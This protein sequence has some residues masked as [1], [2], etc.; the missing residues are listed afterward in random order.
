KNTDETPNNG[1]DDD[2]NGYVDDYDGWNAYNSTGNIPSANHGTHVAGIAGAIGNNEIGISGVNWN[3]KTMPIAGSSGNEATVV[4]AYAYA[5][6]MRARY[7]ETDGDEGAFIVVTNT[8]FG[9]DMGDPTN[10][11]IWCSMY[12]ELGEVGILSC[13]ATANA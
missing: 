6:E 8:S 4:E 9:V 3:V 13:A 1:I 10:F 7:N 2:N 11:P 5:L 12:D